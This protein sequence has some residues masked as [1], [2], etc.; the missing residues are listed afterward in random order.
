LLLGTWLAALGLLIYFSVNQVPI[1]PAAM[2]FTVWLLCGWISLRAWRAS[3]AGLLQWDGDQWNWIQGG[4]GQT[5][6]VHMAWDFQQLVLVRVVVAEA[7]SQW[8]WLESGGN[9]PQ[10]DALRRA[11]VSSSTGVTEPSPTNDLEGQR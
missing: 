6:H 10:W 9:T 7:Q 1:Q 3:A 8:L 5:C 11:L 4:E 2:L